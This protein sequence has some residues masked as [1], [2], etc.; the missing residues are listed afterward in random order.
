MSFPGESETKDPF[1]GL[2][3]TEAEQA[4]L[5]SI[6]L[7]NR[8]FENIVDLV[9]ARDFAMPVHGRI[10]TAI[11]AQIGAGLSADAVGLKA[12]FDQDESLVGINGAYLAQ[13][14]QSVVTL[15][16]APTYARA[17][18]DLA[19]RRDLVITAQDLQADAA[20]LANTER[21]AADVVADI[22]RR[23]LDIEQA[24]SQG[25]AESVGD[26]AGRVIEAAAA[27]YRA[28]GLVTIDTG[29]DDL[30]RI[31]SGM[32]AGALIIVGARPSMGKTALANTIAINV[33][34][35]GN[36]V[37]FFSLE[38]TREQLGQRWIASQTGIETEDQRRGRLSDAQWPQLVEAQQYLAGLPIYVDDQPRLSVP[39]MR[40]RAR[41]QKRRL[42]GRMGLVI[43]DHLQHV[44][45]GG[46][47]ESRRLEIGDATSQL[48]AMAKEL[49]CPVLVLSQLSRAV[50]QRDDKRPILSD[51]RESGD[52][53][54]DADVV[55][56]LYREE[57]YLERGRPKR[58]AN[59]SATAFT[60]ALADY[61]KQLRDARGL[62]EVAVPKNRTGRVGNV[63][64]AWDADRQRF[65]N[66]ARTFEGGAR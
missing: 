2:V 20:D 49:G 28:G 66:L 30:D 11:A 12:I 27:A 36:P 54:Q 1:A 26:I 37:M 61:E 53:E 8:V 23:L 29:I 32:D 52:I 5:G 58:G 24:A 43:V 46:K 38:M 39:Q 48:K 15:L 3:N 44:R 10:F 16:N 6:L 25:V 65:E 56:F 21:T 55:M 47:T 41:R 62:A 7:D 51:L 19:R 64:L 17:V 59:Q 40:Q 57:Y 34:R 60:E 14:M 9:Q 18:A 50:E 33:A 22:E 63:R 42:R 45:Q 13:L 35:A 4:L 31:L